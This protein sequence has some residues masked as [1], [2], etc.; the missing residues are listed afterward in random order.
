P[1]GSASGRRIA[2][3]ATLFP[4]AQFAAIRGNVDTRLR[5]LC[6]GG[7][8]ALVLASAGMKRL[9]FGARISA[10][11]PPA[12]CIPAPGQGIVAIEIRAGDS[13][14]RQVLQAINDADAAAALDAERAL[15]AALGGGCQLPL[16]AVALLDRGELAMH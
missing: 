9:G 16:G 13:Q 12:D 11:I 10:P 6:A 1:F 4:R 14:T 3:L 15:V 5:K 2:Q 8:D 7:F